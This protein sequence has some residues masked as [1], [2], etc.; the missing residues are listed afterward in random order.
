M[1]HAHRRTGMQTQ[2]PSRWLSQTPWCWQTC[3]MLV[4]A[5]VLNDMYNVYI[6]YVNAC[7]HVFSSNTSESAI[8]CLHR[9]F[10][11]IRSTCP[12]WGPLR[13]IRVPAKKRPQ[14]K[15]PWK[16]VKSHE[17]L[18]VAHE[19]VKKLGG[20]IL[21][22]ICACIYRIYAC[23]IFRYVRMLCNLLFLLMLLHDFEDSYPKWLL[24][25]LGWGFVTKSQDVDML[26][27]ARLKKEATCGFCAKFIQIPMR[28][29]GLCTVGSKISHSDSV[30]L[31]MCQGRS[32][33]LCCMAIRKPANSEGRPYMWLILVHGKPWMVAIGDI[34][35][36]MY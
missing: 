10:P 27:W 25:G 11:S 22:S 21:A 8:C 12:S 17:S 1:H 29:G 32:V 6:A 15:I 30:A 26:K 20:L 3:R 24:L 16:R 31:W 33:S 36:D 2:L 34:Y 5:D 13:L 9:W 4:V 28:H 23:I 7:Y 19:Q 35:K 14:R 18:Q